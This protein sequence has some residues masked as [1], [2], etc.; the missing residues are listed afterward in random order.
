L[1]AIEKGD[2]SWQKALDADRCPKCGGS[3]EH[4]VVPPYK[5]RCSVCKLAII[6]SSPTSD[7]I[8]DDTMPSEWEADMYETRLMPTEEQ[9]VFDQ[10]QASRI[11]M[12]D[13]L[14]A[15]EAAVTFKLDIMQQATQA[16]TKEDI[17]YLEAAWRR[18]LQG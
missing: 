8:K 16:Y 6:D 2:G 15:V 12:R 10:N 17:D 5:K 18:I 14:C 1:S 11:E 9:I 4:E 7:K 3:I 13:A